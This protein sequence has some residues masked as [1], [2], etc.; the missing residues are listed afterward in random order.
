MPERRCSVRS[1]FHCH[2]SR[3]AR[4]KAVWLTLVGSVC[5]EAAVIS[6]II[7]FFGIFGSENPTPAP[8]LLIASAAFVTGGLAVCLL[9]AYSA[10]KKTLRH[11]RYTYADIQLKFAAVSRY[12]GEMRI[13]GSNTIF[14]DLYIIPFKTFD[15][16]VPTEDGRKIV[17]RGKIRKYSMDSDFLGYH[18]RGGDVEFDKMWLNAGGFEEIGEAVIP[19]VFGK[20]ERLCKALAEAK[21]RF[22]E[23][24]A[25]RKYVFKEADFIRRR[26]KKRVMP[27]DLDYSRSWK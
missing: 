1:Y 3:Y 24:P 7:L 9:A 17:I 27:E 15:S 14:R 2:T 10:D 23:I 22:D 18:V 19:A 12:E 11:S 16:A 20:P 6:F 8:E 13:N 4:R 21:E 5:A 26:P 25:P